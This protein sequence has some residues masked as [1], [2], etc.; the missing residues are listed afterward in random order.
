M[1]DDRTE[2]WEN[3]ARQGYPNYSIS[4]WGRVANDRTGRHMALSHNQQD[5][6]KVSLVTDRGER[7]TAQVN[8]LVA[9]AFIDPPKTPAFDSLIHLDGNKDHVFAANLAWRPRWF[10]LQYHAQFLDRPP[11]V[12]EPV[13]DVETGEEFYDSRQA[14]KKYGLLEKDIFRSTC[15]GIRVF[16]TGQS[17]RIGQME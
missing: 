5:Y 2:I 6:V 16:P 17:F 14:A 13:W 4:N 8:H 10:A 12:P 3:L 7:K 11:F 15:T 1:I 9:S